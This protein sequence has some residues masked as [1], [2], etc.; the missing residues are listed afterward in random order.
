MPF[1]GWV[2]SLEKFTRLEIHPGYAIAGAGCLLRDLHAAA[3]RIAASSIRPIPPR[4]A[5]PS[6][7]TS[8]PTPAARAA[9]ATAPRAAGWSACASCWPTAASSISAAASAIDFDPG[10]IPLPHVTKNTAGYLLRP[11]MDWVDLFIGSEGTLGVVTEATAA[12]TAPR[13]RLSWPAS[14]SSPA[15]T[16]P[17]AP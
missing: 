11:G 12:L 16:P 2:L 5:P 4:P 10:T 17:S 6:A 3:H 1:G 8:P 14:S 7:A 15:T 13:P 9:S